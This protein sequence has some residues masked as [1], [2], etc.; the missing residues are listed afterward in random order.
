MKAWMA[1]AAELQV[2][3]AD[4]ETRQKTGKG[5]YKMDEKNIAALRED[6]TNEYRASTYHRGG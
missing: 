1:Q 5:F 4:Q 6:L 2:Y 3:S